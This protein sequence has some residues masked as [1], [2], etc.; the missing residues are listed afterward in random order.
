MADAQAT[1]YRPPTLLKWAYAIVILGA[2]VPLGVASSGWV[3][4]ATG[5]SFPGTV[6]F[7]GPLVFLVLGVYR[8]YLVARIPGAL[9]SLPVEG[10]ALALRRLGAACLYFGAA[11]A[12][13]NLAARPLM[14]A[15]LTSRTES[16]AEFF[17]AGVYL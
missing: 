17:V 12:L 2:V 9:V 16:G 13:L 5:S 11:V 10:F 14:R 3:A 8:A 6:P 15:L 1:L 4:M 7:L